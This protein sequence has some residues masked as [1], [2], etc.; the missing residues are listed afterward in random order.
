MFFGYFLHC[1]V[2]KRS[3]WGK[4]TSYNV[5]LYSIYSNSSLLAAMHIWMDICPKDNRFSFRSSFVSHS[6]GNYE[7]TNALFK[8]SV[9]RI[10][11]HKMLFCTKSM[12][13]YNFAYLFS[14]IFFFFQD[15]NAN[16]TVFQKMASQAVSL[17]SAFQLCYT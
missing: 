15:R 3:E 10:N 14:P 7:K 6:L 9:L 11:V 2:T 13:H 12:M 8:C 4:T 17:S 5:Y 16:Y 1:N